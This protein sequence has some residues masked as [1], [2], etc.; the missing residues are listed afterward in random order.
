MQKNTLQK[1]IVALPARIVLNMISYKA[2][3]FLFAVTH[4]ILTHI[5]ILKSDGHGNM[6]MAVDDPRHDEFPVKIRH[7]ALIIRKTGIIAD[8][9]KFAILYR[10]G[11][12]P[13]GFRVRCKDFCVSYDYVCLH[14]ASF[15]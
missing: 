14:S 1:E 8:I 6:D 5:L 3:G 13:Q 12:S 7:L 4:D 2:K 10:K 15:Y 9:N 11:C